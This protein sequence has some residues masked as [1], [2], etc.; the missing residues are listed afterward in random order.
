MIGAAWM[1]R[2]CV[3][4]RSQV[5]C[6]GPR[7]AVAEAAIADTDGRIGAILD[8]VEQAGA[9]ADTAFVLLA[10]HGMEETNP[11]V[12]GDWDAALAVAGVAFRDEGHGFVYLEP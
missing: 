11:E 5:S 6:H 8:A 4:R 7:S 2:H 9:L 12:R 1:T 10:D 3:P